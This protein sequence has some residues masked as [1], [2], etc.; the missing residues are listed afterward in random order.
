MCDTPTLHVVSRETGNVLPHDS[1]SERSFVIIYFSWVAK[2]LFFHISAEDTH[3]RL[4][5]FSTKFSIFKISLVP[6]CTVQFHLLQRTL[7][8]YAVQCG[9]CILLQLPS[10]WETFH[11][12]SRGNGNVLPRGLGH[13][14]CT[15]TG[16]K[17]KLVSQYENAN[18]SLRAMSSGKLQHTYRTPMN[19]SSTKTEHYP[20]AF[21]HT[22]VYKRGCVSTLL[23]LYH[24]HKRQKKWQNNASVE[25][26]AP[27]LINTPLEPIKNPHDKTKTRHTW[28]KKNL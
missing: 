6:S 15:V 12:V 13:F 28:G 14:G 23:C 27:R 3:R 9:T 21:S 5:I 4:I 10:Y 11:P 26:K 20:G 7:F 19:C 8:M 18:A 24:N 16:N 1:N 25:S 2:L 17:V 22:C